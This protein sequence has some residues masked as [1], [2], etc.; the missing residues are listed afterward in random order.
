MFCL[1]ACELA[2]RALIS[3]AMM[4]MGWRLRS[5]CTGIGRQLHMMVTGLMSLVPWTLGLPWK[6]NEPVWQGMA[7]MVMDTWTLGVSTPLA[8]L[9]MI[10]GLMS[11]RADQLRGPIE[12]GVSS[13]L[14]VQ[15]GVVML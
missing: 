15:L 7:E 12:S 1:A 5:N 13:R 6:V 10:S 3:P 2:S 4:V 11:L 9:N 14:M 8:G